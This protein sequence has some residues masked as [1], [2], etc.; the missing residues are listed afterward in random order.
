MTRHQRLVASPPCVAAVAVAVPVL[1]LASFMTD[2]RKEV[3]ADMLAAVVASLG[4]GESIR[5]V[6]HLVS[7]RGR[8]CDY[9]FEFDLAGSNRFVAASSGPLAL[10]MA[11]AFP[12]CS[13]AA[14]AQP[15][16]DVAATGWQS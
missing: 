2:A 11:N 10:G 12:C 5:F 8:P 7:Q 9:E 14:I 3:H 15:S 4:P 16:S 1:R 13:F 6:H